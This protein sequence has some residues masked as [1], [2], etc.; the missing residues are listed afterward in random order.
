MLNYRILEEMEIAAVSVIPGDE[1]SFARFLRECFPE[2][3][4]M[5]LEDNSQ[6]KDIDVLES[7]LANLQDENQELEYEKDD[8]ESDNYKLEN[9]V[10]RLEKE[11]E[12]LQSEIC[13]LQRQLAEAES[14]KDL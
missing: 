4:R 1:L 10:S 12:D 3:I 7:A 11:N 5:L 2:R 6:K 8:L 9:D 13:E 14:D